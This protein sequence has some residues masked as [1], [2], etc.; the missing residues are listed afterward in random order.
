LDSK[1]FLEL[2][3]RV[4]HEKK[5][6]DIEEKNAYQETFLDDSNL[7]DFLRIAE[8]EAEEKEGSVETLNYIEIYNEFKERQLK[9]AREDRLNSTK[10]KKQKKSPF[11]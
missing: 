9:V 6:R 4:E 5:K 1:K 10:K 8:E 11:S 7:L 3:K 2:D